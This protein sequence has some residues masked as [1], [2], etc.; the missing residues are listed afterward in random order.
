MRL[1]PI[2]MELEPLAAGRHSLRETGLMHGHAAR[3][4]LGDFVGREQ[5]HS[6]CRMPPFPD[7]ILTSALPP[8]SPSL[9]M[10][11][12][13]YAV[14]FFFGSLGGDGVQLCCLARTTF[15]QYHLQDFQVPVDFCNTSIFGHHISR[16]I[17]SWDLLLRDISTGTGLLQPQYIHVDVAHF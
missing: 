14:P 2:V 13:P 8:I 9:L 5:R 6:W 10:T 15:L 1:G 3:R 16:I 11:C 12:M 7:P 17:L 4:P